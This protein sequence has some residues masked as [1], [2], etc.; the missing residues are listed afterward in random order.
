MMLADFGMPVVGAV[1]SEYSY[2]Q[3]RFGGGI[4]AECGGLHIAVECR[5]DEVAG[6]IECTDVS[7]V[8][9]LVV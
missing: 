8:I 4:D 3:K 5:S 2:S 9:L 1:A 6:G 7:V